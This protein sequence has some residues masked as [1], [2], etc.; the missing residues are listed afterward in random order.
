MGAICVYRVCVCVVC[1]CLS[2]SE[3]G[4]EAAAL[5]I[6]TMKNGVIV[7]FERYIVLKVIKPYNGL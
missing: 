4:E 1:V 3:K 7:R 5:W 2:D 6:L